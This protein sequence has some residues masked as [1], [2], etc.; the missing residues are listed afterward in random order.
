MIERNSCLGFVVLVLL[1]RINILLLF[2]KL[3][4]FAVPGMR[5]ILEKRA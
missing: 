1:Y 2:F 5:E 3:L 4:C